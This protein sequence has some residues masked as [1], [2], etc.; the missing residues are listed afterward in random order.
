MKSS[1]LIRKIAALC[2]LAYAKHLICWAQAPVLYKETHTCV[3]NV[4]FPRREEKSTDPTQLFL[5]H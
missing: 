1:K 2:S 5:Y 4:T 3:M